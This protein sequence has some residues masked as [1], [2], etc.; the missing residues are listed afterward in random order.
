MYHKLIL[1]EVSPLLRATAKLPVLTRN[2]KNFLTDGVDG[3]EEMEEEED[4]NDE[5]EEGL[6]EEDMDDE[7]VDVEE[8]QGD[9]DGG[10][11]RLVDEAMKQLEETFLFK[12]VRPGTTILVGYEEDFYPGE[13]EAVI[14]DSLAAVNFMER[15]SVKQDTYKWPSRPDKATVHAKFVLACDLPMT[16]V[17]G[18]IWVLQN[19]PFYSSLYFAFHRAYF[20]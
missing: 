18:R 5:Q 12:D 3:E 2:L 16:S 6:D 13:V 9:G 19:A 7:E 15:C 8:Q 20:T 17:N 1:K 4:E 11:E 10:M 14:E